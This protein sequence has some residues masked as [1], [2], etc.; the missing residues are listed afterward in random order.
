MNV[1]DVVIILFMYAIGSI[2]FAYILSLRT[3][4]DLREHGSRNIGARNAFEVTK[5]KDIGIS[6]LIL[7]VLKGFFPALLL[8]HYMSEPAVLPLALVALVAGH[9]YSVWLRFHGGRG[10][11]TAAGILLIASPIILAAWLVAYVAAQAISKDVHIKTVAA[12]CVALATV[13]ILNNEN[14][15]RFIFASRNYEHFGI[16]S[17]Q[18][19]F[20]LIIAIIFTRH[21][22]PLIA[23]F[24]PTEI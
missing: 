19:A 10:L 1:S 4:V 14:N 5:R 6:V 18:A 22:T 12:L 17:L 9:C 20:A 16:I 8:D 21:L 11:A 15:I 24:R 3:G 13:F 2:P 7:D 23:K